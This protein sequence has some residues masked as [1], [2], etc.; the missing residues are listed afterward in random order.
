MG[1]GGILSFLK[2]LLQLPKNLYLQN[3][4]WN[5]PLDCTRK[6]G[7]TGERWCMIS[8][9]W[10]LSL[11][12]HQRQDSWFSA[13]PL[14]AGKSLLSWSAMLA[15][16]PFNPYSLLFVLFCL[17]IYPFLLSLW[18]CFHLYRTLFVDGL[19]SLLLDSSFI[20]SSSISSSTGLSFLLSILGAAPA[21]PLWSCTAWS[22]FL[23]FWGKSIF[24]L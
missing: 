4:W 5:I 23:I 13:S 17:K 3:S 24:S 12:L 16:F 9:T 10:L 6:T 1:W 14:S 7:S 8:H 18:L 20:S 19:T 15:C 11:L 21:V 22:L 2:M